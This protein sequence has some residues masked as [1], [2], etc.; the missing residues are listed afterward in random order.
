[1]TGKLL[2]KLR[3]RAGSNNARNEQVPERMEIG[4][5]PLSSAIGQEFALLSLGLFFGVLDGRKPSFPGLGQIQTDHLRRCR[6]APGSGPDRGIGSLVSEVVAENL[7]N[8][9]R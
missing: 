7:G 3:R 2:S 8:L 4:V 5:E 6:I 1:M 9:G